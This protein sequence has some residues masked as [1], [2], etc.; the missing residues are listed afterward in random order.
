MDHLGEG[1]KKVH[2]REDRRVFYTSCLVSHLRM[3]PLSE[4]RLPQK[5]QYKAVNKTEEETWKNGGGCE[6]LQLAYL[7]SWLEWPVDTQ[8]VS[9]GFQ[10][11]LEQIKV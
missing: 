10:D 3:G 4:V 2:R 8:G 9:S 11:L 5:V 7:L 1:H 6:H